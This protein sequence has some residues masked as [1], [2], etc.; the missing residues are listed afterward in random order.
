MSSGREGSEQPS[1]F[2]RGLKRTDSII[3]IFAVVSGVAAA[4][5]A[6]VAFY[7]ATTISGSN[8]QTDA[9]IHEIADLAKATNGELA[10]MNAEV[11]Q[12]ARQ[13][14]LAD[15]AR[16]REFRPYVV[17]AAN[18]WVKGVDPMVAIDQVGPSGP[19]GI[20]T[21]TTAGKS[22]TSNARMHGG[23]F[24]T[25]KG[26]FGGAVPATRISIPANL[27]ADGGQITVRI[28]STRPDEAGNRAFNAGEKVAV[29]AG[30][31]DYLD[32]FQNPHHTRFCYYIT[33]IGEEPIACRYGNSSD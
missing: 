24:F 22:P 27:A 13:A 9:A 14:D 16:R 2:E 11:G 6:G 30:A 15:D 20:M 33:R 25:R 10:A 32:P 18:L 21:L 23:A 28:P 19:S 3:A 29:M 31:I 12:L 7:T 5:S 4:T 8:K 26:F 1:E 17:P